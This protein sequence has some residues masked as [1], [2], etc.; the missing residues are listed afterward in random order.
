MKIYLSFITF[1]HIFIIC[2]FR[3]ILKN[4][5]KTP[6][7]NILK[8]FRTPYKLTLFDI[9]GILIYYEKT[10]HN[11]GVF[12]MN[13]LTVKTLLACFC[14]TIFVLYNLSYKSSHNGISF[15]DS[16][17][18]PHNV[19]AL[20]PNETDKNL[21]NKLIP[22][23]A[24]LEKTYTPSSNCIVY[25]PISSDNKIVVD[26]LLNKAKIT[27]LFN[28]VEKP[29]YE[30]FWNLGK[31]KVKAI[32][33]FEVQ[34]NEGPLQAEK[35]KISLNEDNDWIV[36]IS[37]ITANEIMAKDLATNLAIKAN[38]INTGGRWQYKNKSIVYFYQSE[39]ADKVPNEVGAVIEKTFSISKSACQ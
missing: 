34:K 28:T 37:N 6:Q 4:R 27:S 14:A 35:Y 29:V 33:L 21:V 10:H 3:L 16:F 38:K 36:S 11:T 39:N 15:V 13:H 24:L 2:Q 32:E 20:P 5:A 23:P 19:D 17:S 31:D 1:K 25:G 12:F 18:N 9:K 22:S 30:V 26:M 8:T 7:K